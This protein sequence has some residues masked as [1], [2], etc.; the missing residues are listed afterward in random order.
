MGVDGIFYSGPVGLMGQVS[1]GETDSRET[2]NGLG[3]INLL[4]R[5]AKVAGYLQLR[6]F[7]EKFGLGWEDAWSVVAGARFTPNTHWAVSFQVEREL[8]TFGKKPEQSIFDFQL[9]YRL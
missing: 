3:E 7:N 1:V 9:R 4:S 2:V 8:T 6:S 5:S